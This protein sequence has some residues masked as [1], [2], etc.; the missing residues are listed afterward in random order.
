MARSDDPW[1]DRYR[2]RW[3]W[4]RVTW[5]SHEVD[6]YP[7]GCSWRVFTKNGKILREEQAG[8]FPQVEP[9][10]PDMNPMGCQKGACWSHCHYSP[11]R[12]THPL[13]RVGER[14][15]GKFERVSWDEAL[16]DIADAML[17]AIEEQGAESIIT[18]LTPELGAQPARLFSEALG[19]PS[20]DGNAEFQDFSPGWHITWGLFN[21]TSSMDDWFLAELTLIWHANPVYTNIQWYHYV[22]ESRYNGGEVVT[23]APDYSPSAIHADHHLP[24]RIGTDAALALAMCKVIIDA[25]L[26]QKQFVQEQ[27]D[28]PLLV[29]NDTGR[30]LRGS[31]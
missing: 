16:T 12:I 10:I 5:G 23:I 19:L 20:T 21:P 11:D 29:R 1:S 26:Y 9:G 4:D 8:S 30:F 3:K 24:V 31:E 2:D 18:P 6:C 22:A 15:A 17:D 25:E 14:G 7:A 27:T 28:L 13:K